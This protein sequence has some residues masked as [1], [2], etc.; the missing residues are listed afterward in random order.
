MLSARPYVDGALLSRMATGVLIRNYTVWPIPPQRLSRRRRQSSRRPAARARYR[1]GIRVGVPHARNPGK[2]RSPSGKEFM[3]EVQ[4]SPCQQVRQ[5]GS[6]NSTQC[7]EVRP[8]E[9]ASQPGR[10][11]PVQQPLEEVLGLP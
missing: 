7:P 10:E 2:L 5:P 4:R 8:A 6:P 1:E 9:P 11:R 3:A